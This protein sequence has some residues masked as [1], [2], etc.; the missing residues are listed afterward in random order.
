MST[1]SD[2]KIE[3]KIEKN[4]LTNICLVHNNKILGDDIR[5]IILSLID[6][7]KKMDIKTMK[8]N[9]ELSQC[10]YSKIGSNDICEIVIRYNCL[11]LCIN[12]NVQE[13]NMD[14]CVCDISHGAVNFFI[15]KISTK[16]GDSVCYEYSPITV[17]KVEITDSLDYL[18]GS[19]YVN[20]KEILESNEST[21]KAM[22][23]GLSEYLKSGRQVGGGDADVYSKTINIAKK[24]QAENMS[25]N[26]L[27]Y[28]PSGD[29]TKI[30]DNVA[31]LISKSKYN[32]N[33]KYTTL[34]V[35]DNNSIN[36]LSDKP[37]NTDVFSKLSVSKNG[38]QMSNIA[39][40]NT[41][42]IPVDVSIAMIPSNNILLN[43]DTI[44]P[45]TH[46]SS[47]GYDIIES[48]ANGIH[49]IYVTIK[50]TIVNGLGLDNQ[51]N[52][53]G[54]NISHGSENSENFSDASK[55]IISNIKSD[56]N[57]VKKN[58]I[59][60]SSEIKNKV[61][62]FVSDKKSDINKKSSEIKNKVNSFVSDKKSDIN[63]KS[64]EIKN[65]VNS[66]VSDKKS[67]INKKSSE[68]KNKVNSFVSDK[69]SDINKKSSEIK[70]NISNDGYVTEN[71]SEYKNLF[72]KKSEKT[73]D[74]KSENDN[75]SKM[76]KNTH[77]QK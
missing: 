46:K 24:S 31:D 12:K 37:N 47:R 76:T 16:N 35:P 64:S 18:L 26:V 4:I 11:T 63:K 45:K 49:K 65:K 36:I 32:P 60:K 71:M 29:Q 54:D 73:N 1:S 34:I 8:H 15:K 72:T 27:N 19:N 17:V 56:L 55:N 10:Y 69:K 77:S 9:I 42:N 48:L 7:L 40:K 14:T 59:Q 67:D 13:I 66:F 22:A 6:C 52:I 44:E 70:K 5:N 21:Q 20:N 3:S 61:N 51:K 23:I 38:N 43:P 53:Y 58:S 41:A 2:K 30:A 25:P 74:N 57:N 62:S 68:I 33:K 28:M 50:D 75:K 39:T